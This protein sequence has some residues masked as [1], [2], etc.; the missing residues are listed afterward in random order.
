MR[1]GGFM[2]NN[3]AAETAANVMP[4][5][6]A[7]EKAGYALGDAASLSVFAL[8][9]SILQKYY[10]DVLN[11]LPS[12]ITLLF[13]IARIWDAVNDPIWGR[14]VD[15]RKPSP[16]GRYRKWIIYMA[17]PVSLSAVLMFLKIPGLN[18]FGYLVYA[19]VTYILFGMLYTTINIPYGSLA[20]V[21]TSD[22]KDRS[23]LSIV[24]SIGSI[25]GNLPSM[26]LASLCYVTVVLADGSR[27]KEMSAERLFAGVLAIAAFCTLLYLLCARWTKER[28][29]P[30]EKPKAEKGTTKKILLSLLKSRPFMTLCA[31]SLLLLAA[32]MFTQAYY[33]YVFDYYFKRP[34]LY[35]MVMVC[36]YLPVGVLMFVTN[37]LI[38]KFGKKALCAFGLLFAAIVNF[39]LFFLQ[40]QNVYVFLA[41][42]FVGGMGSTFFI[43]EIWAMV[44]DVIDHH[45]TKTGIRE[46]ATTYSFFTFTRKLGQTV[47]GVF[48]TQALVWIGYK[49][50]G[51]AQSLETVNGMYKIALLVPAFMFLLNFAI[52]WFLYPSFS[53]KE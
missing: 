30:A 13:L 41:L 34:E 47:A 18:A 2:K 3:A 51:A 15:T 4:K 29:V 6:T 17:V 31:A 37:K 25:L 28:I 8:V 35:M 52:L 38:S 7:K 48:S 20:S 40:T 1:K 19:Y 39:V 43:L 9:G 23:T 24:R 42:C 46:E 53:L 32:Q 45:E 14:F 26:L 11:I 50:G 22:E 16:L 27:V 33:I 21:M 49:V 44:N 36:S 5:L 10:T 12:A